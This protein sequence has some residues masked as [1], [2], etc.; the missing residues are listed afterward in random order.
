[1]KKH[2]NNRTELEVNQL[3]NTLAY[4]KFFNKIKDNI[5]KDSLFYIFK[6]LKFEYHPKRSV[7]CKIGEFGKKFYIILK[8]QVKIFINKIQI[9]STNDESS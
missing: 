2:P 8:G 4:I 3:H 6:N 9:N 1:M 5:K 7:I